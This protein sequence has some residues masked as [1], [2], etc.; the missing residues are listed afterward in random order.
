MYLAHNMLTGDPIQIES[1]FENVCRC[2]EGITRVTGEKRLGA[3]MRATVYNNK[4]NPRILLRLGIEPGLHENN[5]DL[6]GTVTRIIYMENGNAKKY[7]IFHGDT[8]DSPMKVHNLG[9]MII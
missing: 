1:E 7:F 9:I 4:L 3:R 6:L 2:G 5:N 8:I